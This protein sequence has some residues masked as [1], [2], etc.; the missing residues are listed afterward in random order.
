MPY[1][2]FIK[3]TTLGHLLW[4]V[5][6]TVVVPSASW[7]QGGG[8]FTGV[9]SE[10]VGG[11]EKPLKS[12]SVLV[13]PYGLPAMTDGNGAFSFS[14]LPPGEIRLVVSYVGKVT[15]DTVLAEIPKGSLRIVLRDNSFRLREVDVVAKS[16]DQ[17]LGAISVI[18]RN[19]IEHLQANSLAD[20]MSLVPGGITSN[21]DLSRA[22]QINIRSVVN[23]ETD[24]NAF[25]T[26]IVING[27]PIS[28]NANLQTL[29]PVM[30]GGGAGLGGGAI[31]RG[32]VDTRNVPMYNVESVE[33]IRGVPGV[34]YGD[35]G[36]GTVIVNQRAGRQP[37]LVEAN[38][39]QNVYGVNAS[40][41]FLLGE[42]RGALNLGA[43]YAY[44]IN[45]PVQ[46][47]LSYRRASIDG[48]YTNTYF[49]D[50]LSNTTG[51]TV[52][53]G[54][55]KRGLNPDDEITRTRS[56]AVEKGITLHT[57]GRYKFTK[58]LWLRSIEYSGRISF[59]NKEADY[60]EQ[61][62]AA[63]AAYGMSYVDGAILS[64]RPGQRLYDGEGR[65]ITHI[66]TGEA[67]KYAVYL[68]S[69]YLGVHRVAGKEL[70]TFVSA[71]AHFFNKL[72]N[73]QHSWLLGADFRSEGNHGSGKIF[74]DSLP[75]YRNLQYVNSAYR[76]RSYSDIP[77]LQQLGLYAEDRVV[78]R[79][80]A[81][82][83]Q[84][85]AG[86]RYDRFAKGQSILAPRVN[87]ILEVVPRHVFVRA[88]YGVM[89]KGPSLLYRYP[90]NAY[91]DYVNINEMGTARADA[92]FMTTTRVFDT[93]NADLK[94]ATNTKKEVGLDIHIGKSVLSVTA[95]DEKLKNGYG[96]GPTV[97]SFRPVNYV[98]YERRDENSD[99]FDETSSAP[100]LAKFNMPHNNNR[101][102]KRGLEFQLD[103]ARMERIRTQFS[104]YGAYIR[105][106]SY[107]TDYFYYDE[108]S[109]AGAASRTHIGLYEPEMTARYDRSAVTTVKATHNIPKIG[110]AITLTADI[111]WN[112]SDWTV[113][114]NDSIPTHYINKVDGQ[115]HAFNLSDRELPEFKALLRPVART[116]EVKDSYPPMVNF[117]INLTKEIRDF[118]RISFF[119]NNMFRHY[120]VAQSDRVRSV[121]YTRNIPFFFGFKLGV[122]I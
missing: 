24:A 102:D 52:H 1:P 91:F 19:A 108:Q 53:M 54:K 16:S 56:S 13:Q 109:G 92:V 21:P 84:L 12:A 71:S 122:K 117:N 25:G 29:S 65:E 94:V 83:L 87:G 31:P 4:L 85:V 78:A 104:I 10:V 32:G 18:G 107:S 106:K 15:V 22:R 67:G 95:F 60:Q 14:S 110:L 72:G 86:L 90:E 73:T 17:R 114:G 98:Q 42:K 50:R 49:G 5:L 20:I 76:N 33:V 81:H 97:H 113:Y 75:P 82:T 38:I 34:K 100:V 36:S 6:L 7:A 30:S 55:D 27:S 70:N 69:T 93:Q 89:A 115:V 37:L 80:G 118:M 57:S 35:V 74:A 9:V 120:P 40:K 111:I 58:P 51:L 23:G 63:N 39:N 47:Y 112:E 2:I 64:N 119:A 77:T 48:L 3:K 66:P 45:D 96:I 28:N 44:N 43:A 99:I 8:I 41:G 26:S 101:I 79:W 61:Y 88:G 62:T 105:Q 59:T 121:Y 11:K 46:S 103:L 68:P 116:L